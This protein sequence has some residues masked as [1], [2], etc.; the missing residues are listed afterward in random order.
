MEWMACTRCTIVAR[1]QTTFYQHLRPTNHIL[2]QAA[3]LEKQYGTGESLDSL[4]ARAV[5]YCPQAET[6]WLMRAKEKWLAEDVA[7]AR[8]ILNDA[9]AAN[10]D[11]EQ[12]K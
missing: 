6:L 8:A 1:I 5:S 11:S 7:G 9:F 4:L 12:V 2:P 3:Q 10:P